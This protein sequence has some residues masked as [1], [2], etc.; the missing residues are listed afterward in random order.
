MMRP[1][2]EKKAMRPAFAQWQARFTK[3]K[4]SKINKKN[5]PK[6]EDSKLPQNVMKPGKKKKAMRPA[7]A[8]WVQQLALIVR[9]QGQKREHKCLC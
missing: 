8:Q 7:S 6:I 2:K 5:N 1:V 4:Q 3:K 9:D